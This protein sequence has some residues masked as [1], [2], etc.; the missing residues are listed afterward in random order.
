MVQ[1]DKDTIDTIKKISDAIEGTGFEMNRFKIS[2]TMVE[3]RQMIE[4][5]I[6][7]IVVDQDEGDNQNV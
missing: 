4:L 6:R 7:R 2:D 3:N 5:D 1:L